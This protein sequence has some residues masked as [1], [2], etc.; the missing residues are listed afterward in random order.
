M[1]I[2]SIT[3]QSNL[4]F[5]GKSK[6]V[7]FSTIEKLNFL[8][9]NDYLIYP[10]NNVSIRQSN[11]DKGLDEN[12]FNEILDEIPCATKDAEI[13]RTLWF[14]YLEFNKW[15]YNK[16]SNYTSDGIICSQK[17]L[18]KTGF[19]ELKNLIPT[20]VQFWS[21]ALTLPVSEAI[22]E[23]WG[24]IIDQIN[25]QRLRSED[26][27]EELVGTNDK[28]VFKLI[29]GPPSGYRN[30]RKVLKAALISMYGTNY[31][32][33][34]KNKFRSQTLGKYVTSK[35]VEK[36]NNQDKCLPFFK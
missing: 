19:H 10:R 35:V 26:G 23:T 9:N 17:F 1:Y 16:L 31:A 4:Y 5:G 2:S 25:K 14:E 18:F 7:K 11:T 13:R 6:S 34:F 22:C 15:M 33:H 24:S 8:F 30:T 3:E 36:I 28:R 20:F 27:N 29:N 32:D 12:K 21:S